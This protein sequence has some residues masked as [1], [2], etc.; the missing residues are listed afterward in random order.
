MKK[1]VFAVAAVS[2]TFFANAQSDIN[3]TATTEAVAVKEENDQKVEIKVEE[4]PAAIQTALKGTDYQGWSAKK[5]FVVKGEKTHYEVELT[6]DK[7][8]KAVVKFNEDGTVI[9]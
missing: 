6:N 9:K 8:E 1:L 2:A 7:A 5:A 4:L 3:P